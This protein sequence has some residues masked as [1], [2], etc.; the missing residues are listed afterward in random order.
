MPKHR[1][2]FP[3]SSSAPDT[4]IAWPPADQRTTGSASGFPE[5]QPSQRSY[6]PLSIL[7]NGASTVPAWTTSLAQSMSSFS[8]SHSSKTKEEPYSSTTL[9]QCTC[10]YN[11]VINKSVHAAVEDCH[12]MSTPY[13]M[14]GEYVVMSGQQGSYTGTAKHEFKDITLA[15]FRHALGWFSTYFDDTVRETSSGGSSVL[16]VQASSPFK[17]NSSADETTEEET[18][19][20]NPY[21]LALKTKIDP[22]PENW[23]NTRRMLISM[24][25]SCSVDC[26]VLKPLVE[27]ALSGEI[28]RQDG[29]DE[30]TLEKATAWKPIDAYTEVTA[31]QPR[32][33]RGFVR[34]MGSSG[35]D[36]SQGSS[37]KKG[38]A[39]H[40]SSFQDQIQAECVDIYV[41]NT[42]LL[43]QVHSESNPLIF[44]EIWFHLPTKRAP[45]LPR[46]GLTDLVS[47]DI[48]K[49]SIRALRRKFHSRKW[50]D[51][52]DSLCG[53]I[54][55]QQIMVNLTMTQAKH[56]A[57][58]IAEINSSEW[59]R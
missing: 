20:T 50:K 55:I 49:T 29:L 9:L 22:E 11:I 44:Y 39:R 21:T 48:R 18:S 8:P 7:Q 51:T 16:A 31:E 3:T 32:P 14:P 54:G 59:V 23:G 25:V 47:Y 43:S 30:I 10:D 35:W 19:W 58:V 40:F 57:S 56:L 45:E 42:Q 53:A 41:I 6:G 36:W 28:S 15:D 12:G 5:T 13:N 27:K 26:M 34:R 4:A 38:S 24:G 46:V 1:L 52:W 37:Y 33:Q 17:Q 2:A